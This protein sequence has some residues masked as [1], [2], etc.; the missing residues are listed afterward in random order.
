L[1]RD[2]ESGAADGR[3]AR[4]AA[5]VL[6]FVVRRPAIVASLFAILAEILPVLP[7]GLLVF[8]DVL[9]VFPELLAVLGQLSLA[10]AFPAVFSQLTPILLPL[11]EIFL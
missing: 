3:P 8:A 6:L 11:A 10:G 1:V 4:H 5:A 7:K 2:E 9:I